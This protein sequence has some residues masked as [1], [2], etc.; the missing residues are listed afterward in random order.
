MQK[1][2]SQITTT[3]DTLGHTH[4]LIESTDWDRKAKGSGDASIEVS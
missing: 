4:H 2:F 3:Q 1:F